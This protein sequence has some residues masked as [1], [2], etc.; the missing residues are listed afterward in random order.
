[1]VLQGHVE[2]FGLPL[3]TDVEHD[4]IG[5]LF[6]CLIQT[7]SYA[8]LRFNLLNNIDAIVVENNYLNMLNKHIHSYSS[9]IFVVNTLNTITFFNKMRARYANVMIFDLDFENST[10]TPKFTVGSQQTLYF[11][12]SFK[13]LLKILGDL[14]LDDYIYVFNS[15]QTKKSTDFTR[16]NKLLALLP[17]QKILVF[18]DIRFVHNIKTT[19]ERYHFQG[20]NETL[21]YTVCKHRKKKQISI[22]TSNIT[23]V[24]V[25]YELPETAL[26][27]GNT[28]LST[29]YQISC[30]D[31]KVSSYY[32][33]WTH[34]PTHISGV[35][36]VLQ[37]VKYG[38]DTCVFT[39]I[40]QQNRITSDLFL[41]TMG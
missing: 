12:P 16:H 40:Y 35:A 11:C 5:I 3:H 20:V 37:F 31:F 24:V 7:N 25:W 23:K 28:Q 10:I 39:I 8:I 29:Y 1:M 34:V 41:Q 9:N 21:S 26:P 22:D 38:Q 30:L 4:L 27:I 13:Q 32:Y 14:T 15:I 33:V 18:D 2:L 36:M 17:L 6:P 19:V